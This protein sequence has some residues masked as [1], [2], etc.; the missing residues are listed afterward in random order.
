MRKEE[1]WIHQP[2]DL[3]SNFTTSPFFKVTSIPDVCYVLSPG[4]AVAWKAANV[5]IGTTVIVFGL[6]AIRKAMKIIQRVAEDHTNNS[7]SFFPFLNLR[8]FPNIVIR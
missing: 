5:K 1:P 2:S 6:G 3:I 8:V 7:S 4:V